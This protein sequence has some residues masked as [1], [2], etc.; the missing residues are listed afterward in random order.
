MK[1]IKLGEFT[2]KQDKR[3]LKHIF[4]I[5]CNEIPASLFTKINFEYFQKLVKKNIIKV[6]SVN[7][8]KS[9]T[10]VITVVDYKNYKILKNELIWFFIKNPILIFFNINH[11]LR[12]L[13]KSLTVSFE[14]LLSKEINIFSLLFFKTLD[15]I[16]SESNL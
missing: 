10:S 4:D 8:G 9:I 15:N 5:I 6:F 12:S 11:L 14:I 13:L 16:S 1:N 7:R 3:N 2:L